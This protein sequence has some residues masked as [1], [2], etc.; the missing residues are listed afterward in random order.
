M[1]EELREKL[2]TE[3]TRKQ[4]L[5]YLVGAVLLLFGFNNLLSLLTGGKTTRYVMM[6]G[7]A[8]HSADGFGARR[9]GV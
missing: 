1:R 7:P 9:F 6:P 2:N 5:E 3:I 8:G 4:F